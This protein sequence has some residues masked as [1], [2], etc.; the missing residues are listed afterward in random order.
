MIVGIDVAKATVVAV[1]IDRSTKVRESATVINTKKELKRFVSD[2][3]KKYTKLIVASEATADYHR[4][5]VRVCLEQHIPFRLINPILTKQFTRATVRKKKTDLTDAHIIAKLCLQGEGNLL[6]V[7]SLELSKPALRMA[8]NLTDMQKNLHL[9]E[10]RLER[11]GMQ[12]RLVKKLTVCQKV[13]AMTEEDY[14]SYA[15]KQ[16]DETV[17]KLLETIPGIGPFTA[18]VLLAEIGDIHKFSN[19]KSLVAFCGLDP[20]VKQSG[21]SLR[22]NTRLTKRGSPYLRRAVF[23]AAHVASI[24]D[25][26]LR[27]YYQKKISEGRKF[28]EATVATARKLLYR[29]FAVWERQSPYVVKG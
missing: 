29:I 5:L 21:K 4:E 25:K 6:T 15:A 26:E 8:M 27:V 7:A 10:K 9:M 23:F 11:L 13:L 14:K 19:G 3:K 18:A 16:Q 12:K 22:R 28:K 17:M 1:V 24:H 20:K 2:L